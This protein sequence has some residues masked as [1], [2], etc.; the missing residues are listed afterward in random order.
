[1]VTPSAIESKPKKSALYWALVL[2]NLLLAIAILGL[3]GLL[4]TGGENQKLAAISSGQHLAISIKSGEVS[5]T[6]RKTD[7]ATAE[8]PANNLVESEAAPA[9][10]AE[11]IEPV[12]EEEIESVPADEESPVESPEDSVPPEGNEDEA[13]G[14][15]LKKKPEDNPGFEV[16]DEDGAA[17]APEVEGGESETAAAS[18]IATEDEAVALQVQPRTAASLAAPIDSLSEPSEQGALPKTGPEGTS[19]RFYA[20]PFVMPVPAK[21]VIAILMVD[22]G[23]N[24]TLTEQAITSLPPEISMAFIPYARELALQFENAR[25]L[26]HESWLMLPAQPEDFPASDPGPLAL[27]KDLKPADNKKRLHGL[28]TRLKGFVGLVLPVNE[29]FS[30]QPALLEPVVKELEERGVAVVAAKSPENPGTADMLRSAKGGQVAFSV[31]DAVMTETDINNA[32]KDLEKQAQTTPVLAVARPTPLTLRL[33]KDW[34]QTLPQKSIL[35]APASALSD[36]Q[37]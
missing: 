22:L 4:F 36:I 25:N 30:E 20:R 7:G 21:P 5:G 26:G 3:A 23:A 9:G 35:L 16:G 29:I 19:R 8:T 33:L 27:L 24:K 17:A 37:K 15:A 1:M 34:A 13:E 28:M 2:I 14:E 10:K 6:M 18:L 32:L 11:P 12:A 31:I